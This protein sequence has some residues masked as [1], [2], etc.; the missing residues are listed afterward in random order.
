[1]NLW[2]WGIR[3]YDTGRRWVFTNKSVGTR[4]PNGKSLGSVYMLHGNIG[5]GWHSVAC[6]RLQ[7][8]LVTSYHFKKETS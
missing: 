3:W 2:K 7:D 4:A 8:L 5:N 6:V 1:M